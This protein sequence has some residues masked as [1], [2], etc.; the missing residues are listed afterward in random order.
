MFVG[1]PGS[2]NNELYNPRG[3]ARDSSSG[4]LYIADYYNHR[5]MRYLFGASS[6]TVVAGGNGQGS[7]NTQL[8]FPI[9]LYFDSTSNSLLIANSVGHNIV[10][11]VIG[12][13]NWTLV[14]GSNSG[15]SGNASTLLNQP[16]D[17]ALDSFG[18]LYVADG[19]NHRIQFFLAGQFNGTTIA[20]TGTASSTA[21]GLNLPTS[22]AVDAQLNLYVSDYQNLRVQKFQR[23]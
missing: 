2:A 11:W 23:Y 8:N 20:G 21:A 17:V 4:T 9:G 7:T 15:A 18:N 1:S 16:Q 13:T 22:V 14:A 3:I 12:A 6:G 19:Y 10:R 5:V